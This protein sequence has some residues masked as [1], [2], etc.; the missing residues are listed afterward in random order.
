MR[1]GAGG[2]HGGRQT[3][4][5]LVEC[6]GLSI[7]I[8]HERELL[9]ARRMVAVDVIL[10]DREWEEWGMMA[11]FCVHTSRVDPLL[12]CSSGV[13][14]RPSSTLPAVLHIHAGWTREKTKQNNHAGR[15][16]ATVTAPPW[17]ALPLSSTLRM[18]ASH[19]PAAWH[20][21]LAQLREMCFKGC[22]KTCVTQSRGKMC[23]VQVPVVSG[24]RC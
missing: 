17:A 10:M 15:D 11:P 13:P 5:R 19:V 23:Q 22:F 9:C 21:N 12:S 6:A 16:V 1:C 20:S 14:S 2:A 8:A 3:G 18:A 24:R 7:L 4:A